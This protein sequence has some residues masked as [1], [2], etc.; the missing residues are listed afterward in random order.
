MSTH[1]L[2]TKRRHPDADRESFTVGHITVEVSRTHGT[3]ALIAGDALLAKD[4]KPLFT[5]VVGPGMGTALRRV[6]HAFD[7]IE[8]QKDGM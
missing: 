6:A 3:F 2:R 7:D 8:D 1:S 5:G 4:R